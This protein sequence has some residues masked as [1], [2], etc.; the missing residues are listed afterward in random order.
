MPH[1]PD[2]TLEAHETSATLYL[3]GTITPCTTLAALAECEHL[4]FSVRMLRVDLRAADWQMVGA[5]EL[6]AWLLW[7]W[8]RW[9]GRSAHLTGIALRMTTHWAAAVPA[10]GLSRR[11]ELVSRLR[12]RLHRVSG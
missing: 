12:G 7:R 3:G 9:P 10:P 5:R 4:P 1:Q 11:V 2:Y 6:L 8:T